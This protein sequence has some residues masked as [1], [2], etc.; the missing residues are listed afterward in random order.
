MG[1][2]NCFRRHGNKG[3]IEPFLIS[4]IVGEVLSHLLAS[5]MLTIRRVLPVSAVE[6][7]TLSRM[8]LL[9]E[10]ITIRFK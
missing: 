3:Q 10:D 8:S 7:E 5:N 4:R 1:E 9:K 6:A 2:Q